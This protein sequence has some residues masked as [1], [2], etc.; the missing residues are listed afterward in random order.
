MFTGKSITKM[1]DYMIMYDEKNKCHKVISKRLHQCWKIV[2]A[3]GVYR[4][5]HKE[6]EDFVTRGSFGTPLECV[7]EISAYDDKALKKIRRENNSFY[8]FIQQVFKK[9]VTI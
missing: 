9:P 7:M 2:E 3:E 4:L 1:S 6:K 8:K 5:L